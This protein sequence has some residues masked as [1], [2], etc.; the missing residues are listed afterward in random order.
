[1]RNSGPVNYITGC[2]MISELNTHV[3]AELNSQEQEPEICQ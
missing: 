1:M 2:V 3:D